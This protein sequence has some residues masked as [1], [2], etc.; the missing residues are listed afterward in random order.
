MSD[1]PER[2]RALAA[3]LEGDDWEHPI[4]A[5]ED[6]LRAAEELER[7]RAIREA[8]R[9]LTQIAAQNRESLALHGHRSLS[10]QAAG[11]QWHA[12]YSELRLVLA[13][14]AAGGEG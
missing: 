4:T 2:L 5:R 14:E 11:D 10:F 9:K 8:A 6:C 12:A 1:L 13:A 7:L 3:S